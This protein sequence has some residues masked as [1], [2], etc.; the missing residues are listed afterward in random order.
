VVRDDKTHGMA[1]KRSALLSRS[2]AFTAL[3]SARALSLVGDGVCNL[4]LIVY[5]QSTNGTGIAVGLLL[6]VDSLPSLLSPITGVF[7]DRVD[8]RRL[9]AACEIVQCLLVVVILVWLPP[10]GMLL[11]L[12]FLKATA[13]TIA[14]PA[15]RSAVPALVADS[16]LVAANAMLGGLRQIAAVVGPLLGGVLVATVDVR[17]ALGVDAV[18]FVVGAILLLRLPPL[19]PALLDDHE[20]TGVLHASW[21][22]LRYVVSHP[23]ARALLVAFFLMGLSAADD[24]ALPFLARDLGAGDVGIGAIYAA[25]A[26]G[27][28]VGFGLLLRVTRSFSPARGFVIGAA[29]GGIGTALTGIAPALSIAIGFQLVRGLGTALVET[30][31]QTLLQRS[32]ERPMLGRVFANVFGAVNISAA[33]SVVLGG[34]LLD[35][36]SPGTV[37]VV[38]GLLAI[39]ASIVAALLLRT[40][41]RGA[42]EQ[43]ALGSPP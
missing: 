11:V 36:T 22:G 6:L 8:Q 24:V 20:K 29:I 43:G 7:S 17:G 16:D 14:D 27:M 42:E 12:L 15:A 41:Q 19:R 13:V 2:P 40:T 10:L 25:S 21:V 4:A 5:V 1:T 23:V 38:A 37:L 30:N 9:L 33:V 34:L 3:L 39:A 35:A 26:V 18:S 31:L 32:V 28:V